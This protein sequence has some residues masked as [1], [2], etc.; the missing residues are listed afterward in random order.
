MLPLIAYDDLIAQIPNVVHQESLASYA[1]LLQAVVARTADVL[2]AELPVAQSLTANNANLRM[3]RLTNGSFDTLDEDVTV[4][5]GLRK[6]D[7]ELLE[8]INAA[9][10]KISTETRNAWMEAALERQ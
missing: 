8:Q 3:V 4:A 6:K 7:T 9:L 1:A 2:V 10:A 5:I